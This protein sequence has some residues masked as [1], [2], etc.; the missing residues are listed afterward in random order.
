MSARQIGEG[1]NPSGLC[2]CG[3]GQRTTISPVSRSDEGLIAGTPV[4]YIRGHARM[5]DESTIYTVNQDTG[6]WDWVGHRNPHGYGRLTRNRRSVMAHRYFYEKYVGPI[7][8][9]TQLDHL[10]RNRACVNPDHLEP[11]TNKENFN[12]GIVSKLDAVTVLD[13]RRRAER[14]ESRIALAECFGVHQ[15]TIAKVVTQRS[16]KDVA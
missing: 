16:W 13:I 15:S 7:P 1:P 11:V 3:C 5:R 9:G 8:V 2:M 12:R 10:C 14:G 4:K 6:C